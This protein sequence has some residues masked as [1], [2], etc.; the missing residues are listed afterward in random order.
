LV[1]DGLQC[2]EAYHSSHDERV[3]QHYVDLADRLGLA[4]T[5]GSDFHGPDTRRAEFF[6]R[7]GLPPACYERLKALLSDAGAIAGR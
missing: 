7:V 6:G 2:V 1:A 4:V 3:Q 5:G